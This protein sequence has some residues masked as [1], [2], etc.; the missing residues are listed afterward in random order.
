MNPAPDNVS[1]F[2]RKAP[3]ATVLEVAKRFPV[4]PCKLTKKTVGG[5]VKAL[6]I[7]LVDGGFK[8]ATQDSTTIINWWT[9]WPDALVGIPT[10]T[11]S[12]LVAVD[13]DGPEGFAWFKANRHQLPGMQINKTNRGGHLLFLYPLTEN[14]RCHASMIADHVDHR[15]DGGYIIWW[16]AHGHRVKNEGKFVEV[17]DWLAAKMSEPDPEP[18]NDDAFADLPLGR[19]SHTAYDV[20]LIL[21]KLD[22]DMG[23]DDWLKV[24]MGIKHQLG[25]AG[26]PIYDGWSS[27]A[28]RKYL[29]TRHVRKRWNSFDDDGGV[30]FRSVLKMVKDLEPK[31]KPMIQF[32]HL[33]EIVAEKREPEWLL[34]DVLEANVLAV[35]VGPRGSFKS[36]VAFDWAMR[37]AMA[38]KGVAIL[39]GEGAGI[40]RRADAWMRTFGEGKDLRDLNVIVF[41]GILNLNQNEIV[42]ELASTIGGAG[43]PVHLLLVDTLSKYSPGMNENDNPEMA[44]FLSRLAVKLRD[45][46]KQTVLLVAHTGHENQQRARGAY[47]LGANTDAEYVVKRSDPQS[48][49]VTVTRERFKDTPSLPLLKY[50]AS[51]VNLERNDKFGRPISSLIL[52]L[53]N[54]PTAAVVMKPKLLKVGRNQKIILQA[55]RDCIDADTGIAKEDAVIDKV[56]PGIP[57]E[58]PK[59]Y[60]KQA[61]QGLE[62]SKAIG[63]D[64][65]KGFIWLLS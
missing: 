60:A 59:K 44:H 2:V 63:W 17:P 64:K 37:A 13:Y 11:T 46:F 65:A 32:R 42:E 4:F 45:V 36:F 52:E 28:K 19:T 5:V 27:R 31:K 23:H 51:T 34:L 43:F 22:P 49:E 7:P 40:D 14:V 38:G 10:G 56:I 29:G 48:M 55:V 39:S 54:E 8:A 26:F 47:T 58:K 6:K 35:L 62:K 1:Y 20:V 50:L 53:D 21:N 15:G 18:S 41:E 24:G 30:T 12:G 33:S 57:G 9:Q 25:D 16:P 3:I 61:L